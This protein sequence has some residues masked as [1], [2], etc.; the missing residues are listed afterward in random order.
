MPNS[1]E[2]G[3]V[4]LQTLLR[5]LVRKDLVSAEEVRELCRAAAQGFDEGGTRQESAAGEPLVD[6]LATEVLDR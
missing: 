4:I 5:L 1:N 2:C 6:S 3:P